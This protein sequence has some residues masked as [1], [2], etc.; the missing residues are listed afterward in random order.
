MS[1]PISCRC[2]GAN[3]LAS[4]AASRTPAT[5]TTANAASPTV[6]RST[7]S[8][9]SA[10]ASASQ[11][12]AEGETAATRLPSPC[13][14]LGEHVERRQPQL[15]LVEVRAERDE[16]VAGAGEA[17]DAD[18]RRE[19]VLGLLHV[20]V[21]GADD[22]VD[23]I[24]RLG[25][26]GQR[27]DRLGAAHAVYALHAAQPAGAEDH[28][29]DLPVHAG[30]SAHGDVDHAGA[31][32][33]DDA[34]HDRARVG[35][36]PAGNVHRGRAD[37]HLA[38]D[39]AL[40]LGKLDGDVL[41]DAGV[42]HERDVGD[43]HLQPG[44]QLQRQPRDRL[45]ELLR[46]DEQRPRLVAGGVEPAR[47]VEHGGVALGA[48]PGQD[49]AHL[50]RDRGA[51][52]DERAQVG[53]GARGPAEPL[54]VVRAQTL[55][56]HL[57]RSIACQRPSGAPRPPA[58]VGSSRSRASSSSIA[59]ALSLCATGLA[60][61]LAV[62]DDDLLAHDQVVL[63]QR[64]AG[65]GQI[66]DRLDHAGQRRELDRALDLDDLG[67]PAGLLEVAGGDARVLGGD[68]HHAQAAQRLERRI[69]TGLARQHHRAAAVAE[70][71]QLVDLA[72]PVPVI[73][74]RT[75]RAARPCP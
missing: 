34:H 20:Q 65:G 66:D 70:V 52:G 15:A 37:G 1:A 23:A 28:R 61:S 60:I 10:A 38:Q 17:V 51:V 31:A 63:A 11:I 67:L 45:V 9:S 57:R 58:V 59:A 24:D 56:P 4:A 14:R 21:A 33:G 27:G 47:V 3:A 22:H 35:R 55:D 32:R 48:H 54:H 49:L 64:G 30:R 2:S 42:G 72:P 43:R 75:A 18:A 68:P 12:A 50:L 7:T 41:A 73:A 62:H 36:A 29:V 53:G 19:L 44:D 8:S 25:A 74:E 69:G 71:E 16:Q 26:V 39:D 13:S 5:S 40:P 6:G 46:G